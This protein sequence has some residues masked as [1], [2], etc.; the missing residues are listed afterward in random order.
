MADSAPA[1]ADAPASVPQFPDYPAA[2]SMD[3]EWFAV[4]DDGFIAVFDTG[5]DGF[6]PEDA[7]NTEADGDIVHMLT[8]PPSGPTPPPPA[9]S[10]H[11][12]LMGTMKRFLGLEPVHSP[13]GDF[14]YREPQELGLYHY[15][16]GGMGVGIYARE[17]R[18]PER[19]LRLADAPEPARA[20]L[21]RPGARLEG[22]RFSERTLIQPLTRK[23]RCVTWYAQPWLDEDGMTTYPPMEGVGEGGIDWDDMA[24]SE[25]RQLYRQAFQH[26][27]PAAG[28]LSAGS[29]PPRELFRLPTVPREWLAIDAEGHVG[30]FQTSGWGA[31]PKGL[32]EDAR[33]IWPEWFRHFAGSGER[34]VVEFGCHDILQRP[35]DTLQANTYIPNGL[36]GIVPE[37][38]MAARLGP[39][40]WVYPLGDSRWLV[41]LEDSRMIQNEGQDMWGWFASLWFRGWSKRW[42]DYRYGPFAP[43]RFGLYEFDMVFPHAAG[44]YHRLHEPAR[45]LHFRELP[46]D[47]RERVSTVIFPNVRFAGAKFLQ[48][49]EHT[50]CDALNTPWFAGDGET[51]HGADGAVMGDDDASQRLRNAFAAHTRRKDWLAGQRLP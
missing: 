15:G 20:L 34:A 5:E 18:L 3:T 21:S 16:Y 27:G 22:V 47:L 39:D 26:R 33:R 38:Q 1:P 41:F 43:W 6:A 12:G 19:P 2:H 48:P 42:E 51:L 17:E 30:F 49:I 4:D 29:Y 35:G 9:P 44:P 46:E 24:E 7:P 28:E 11:G 8:P 31:V 50:A 37:R 32:P 23:E 14:E 10:R 45:P 40:P 25:A 36:L 13:Y